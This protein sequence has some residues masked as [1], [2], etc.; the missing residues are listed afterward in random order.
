VL[1][2]GETGFRDPLLFFLQYF[3]NEKFIIYITS[4]KLLIKKTLQK[5]RIPSPECYS[6]ETIEQNR[7]SEGKYIIKPVLEHASRGIDEN[8]TGYFSC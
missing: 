3:L 4:S 5:L 8:S 7:F 1:A 6:H 2:A